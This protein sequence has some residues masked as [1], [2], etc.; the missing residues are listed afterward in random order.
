MSLSTR[1]P[2]GIP[3]SVRP[4]RSASTARGRE[5]A[6]R[7]QDDSIPS[8]A[9]SQY[10]TASQSQRSRSVPR[11]G[12]DNPFRSRRVQDAPP[13]PSTSSRHSV[14]SSVSSASSGGSVVSSASTAPS[15]LWDYVGWKG[16]TATSPSNH[17]ERIASPEPLESSSEWSIYSGYLT[18]ET[19]IKHI[20]MRP[21]HSGLV[22]LQSQGG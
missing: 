7:A 5:P 3:S 12:T 9:E 11:Q 21:T 15:S 20:Q 1:R 2:P 8:P 19:Q 6:T 17:E 18:S 22:W 13:L 14:Q 10:R 16:S 4:P